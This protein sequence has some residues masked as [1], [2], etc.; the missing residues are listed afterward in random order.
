MLDRITR[1]LYRNQ[2]FNYQLK[3]FEVLRKLGPVRTAH[4]IGSYLK[5]KTKP[6]M[7]DG[8]FENWVVRRFGRQLFK[9]FFKSY[10]EKLWGISCRELD[11]DF[12]AQR[13]KRF[14][15]YEAILSAFHPQGR[16]DHKTLVER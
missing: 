14:S 7:D 6:I 16:I 1:I 2:R 11:S 3:P 10:S 5:E 4:C 13:I 8:T 15:L 12:A 9:I